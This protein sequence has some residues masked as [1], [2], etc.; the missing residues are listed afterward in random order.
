MDALAIRASLRDGF[1]KRGPRKLERYASARDANV[2]KGIMSQIGVKIRFTAS[3]TQTFTPVEM[4]RATQQ[5]TIS[6]HSQEPYV[7][8]VYPSEGE[9]DKLID[10]AVAAQKAWSTVA[11]EN[12]IAI[13]RKFMVCSP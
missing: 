8:R 2:R 13:G 1:Q 4:S 12:R 11:V 9:L 6:P 10:G 3:L 5:T 7:T